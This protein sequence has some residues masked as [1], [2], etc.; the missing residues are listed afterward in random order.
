MAASSGDGH[1]NH[2]GMGSAATGSGDPRQETETERLDRNFDELLQEL[3]V[4]Q[5]G[6]QILFAFLLGVAFTSPFRQADAFV[7]IVYS[8]TLL[9]SAVAAALFIAPVAMHR[10]LFRQGCK[11]PLVQISSR[12]AL[13]GIYLLL[14]ALTGALL[15][16]LD[17]PLGRPAALTLS[18]GVFFVLVLL[19]VALPVRLLMRKSQ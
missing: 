2:E 8:A 13:M 17:D 7:H 4:S 9:L 10:T 19:W 3:R 18:A 14:L 11:G 15:L 5:T 6:T 12:L 1:G 16:A